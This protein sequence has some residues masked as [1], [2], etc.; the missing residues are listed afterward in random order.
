[1]QSCCAFRSLEA[2]ASGRS[3]TAPLRERRTYQNARTDST[4]PF[5]LFGDGGWTASPGSYELAATPFFA[6]GAGWSAGTTLRIAFRIV[7]AA[8]DD[9]VPPS[10]PTDLYRTSANRTSFTV[11]WTPARDNVGVAGYEVF[12][13]GRSAGTTASA[14]RRI[15]DLQ[16]GSTHGVT[17]RAVDR[18]GNWSD[19][20]EPLVVTLPP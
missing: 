13:D 19:L 4:D 6:A 3:K 16:P 8:D 12:V 17:V 15:T 9:R 14:N 1:V 7:Q 2:L 20:S 5:T 10:V 11:A 18:A